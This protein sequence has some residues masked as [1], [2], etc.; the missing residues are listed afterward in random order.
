MKAFFAS[1]H[2]RV[3]VELA[4]LDQE[5][6]AVRERFLN[7]LLAFAGAFGRITNLIHDHEVCCRVRIVMPFDLKRLISAL[8]STRDGLKIALSIRIK[9]V[10]TVF[11]SCFALLQGYVLRPARAGLD[12]P[13]VNALGWAIP[14]LDD[15]FYLAYL[16]ILID[17]VKNCIAVPD[18]S[19]DCK[20]VSLLE[21]EGRVAV[22]AF[23]G[24]FNEA[25]TVSV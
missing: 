25:V 7:P 14:V 2:S 21:R 19:S 9:G 18:R 17:Q 4:V 13:E 22:Y 1:S 12:I 8:E 15:E 23:F 11:V 24:H 3:V 5:N 16:W 6:V 20:P 10:E